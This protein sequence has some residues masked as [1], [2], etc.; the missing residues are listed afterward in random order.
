MD[1]GSTWK[2]AWRLRLTVRPCF[3]RQVSFLFAFDGPAGSVAGRDRGV[4]GSTPARVVSAPG[5][6]RGFLL[7]PGLAGGGSAWALWLA[8]AACGSG[9]FPGLWAASL[10]SGLFS[11]RAERPSDSHSF[12][13]LLDRQARD[14][15]VR[16]SPAPPRA[17]RPRSSG[18]PVGSVPV[19][20][21]GAAG[22]SGRGPG[23]STLPVSLSV[24]L[25]RALLLPGG[26][27]SLAAPPPPLPSVAELLTLPRCGC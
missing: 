19:V 22:G 7:V 23:S 8:A 12:A 2:T 21:R 15:L 20:A 26:L 4:G 11:D 1:P 3:G 10:A 9:C 5:S 17:H 6:R 18:L 25:S 27:P 14:R 16:R 24:C 13:V